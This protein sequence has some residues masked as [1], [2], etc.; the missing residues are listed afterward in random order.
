MKDF[1]THTGRWSNLWDDPLP[2]PISLELM[3]INHSKIC[4]ADVRQWIENYDGIEGRLR[5]FQAYMPLSPLWQRV[6]RPLM[7][8]RTA[9][10]MDVER[11]VKPIKHMILTKQRNRLGDDN[12]VVLFRA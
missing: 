9:G 10:L 4:F 8:M 1:W 6:G 11:V 12:G 3:E 5:F 2:Q 7:S